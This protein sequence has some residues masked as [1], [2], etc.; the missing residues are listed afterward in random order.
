[1]DIFLISKESSMQAVTEKEPLMPKA[2]AV[3]PTVTASSTT[4]SAT[5]VDL[6]GTTW[7]NAAITINFMPTPNIPG[8]YFWGATSNFQQIYQLV[9][10]ATGH[11]SVSL[12]DNTTIT[13]SN[14]TWQFVVAPT[15]TTPAVVFNMMIAGTAMDISSIFTSQSYQLSQTLVQSVAVPRSYADSGVAAPSNSGQ[16]YFNSTTNQ[17]MMWT[18]SAWRPFMGGGWVEVAAGTDANA[19]PGMGV[20]HS[21]TGFTNGPPTTP[22]T[23]QVLASLGTINFAYGEDDTATGI[24][25]RMY[26]RPTGWTAWA[27]I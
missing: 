17:L 16:L 25:S 1:M 5:L 15:A 19:L 23:N 27:A 20:Y 12:P 13:P 8:P 22:T 6:G 3:T 2:V 21:A 9:A 26:K 4:V 7:A 10:D 14:S 18:H 24:F 11:F